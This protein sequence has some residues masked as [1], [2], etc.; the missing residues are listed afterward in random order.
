M[1]LNPRQFDPGE[2]PD[3]L[4][5]LMKPSEIIN[6]LHGFYDDKDGDTWNDITP[7]RYAVSD[8]H[9]NK[10]AE[11]EA[12]GTADSIR[13]EGV[14]KPV[15]LMPP[16]TRDILDPVNKELSR[17]RHFMLGN[18][19]H[20]LAV[21]FDMEQQGSDIHIPVLYDRYIRADDRQEVERTGTPQDL[22][23]YDRNHGVIARRPGK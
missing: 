15:V 11:A 22:A 8:L 16:K 18:G 21:A 2:N 7:E 20:R 9:K 13:K 1:T 3:Q 19:H 6:R 14:L 5:L 10:L 4:Q 23:E 12:H 17:T